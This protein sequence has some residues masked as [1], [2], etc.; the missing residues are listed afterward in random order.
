MRWYQCLKYTKEL[1]H[2]RNQRGETNLCILHI[3]HPRVV[4]DSWFVPV[5]I[6]GNTS[7][8]STALGETPCMVKHQ[9]LQFIHTHTYWYILNT[10]TAWNHRRHLIKLSFFWTITY[11]GDH[12]QWVTLQGYSA[13]IF[14]DCM[15]DFTIVE[16]CLKKIYG[17]TF[18]YISMFDTFIKCFCE[19]HW[20]FC[21]LV[22]THILIML[23][24]KPKFYWTIEN[25]KKLF[26]QVVI[27]DHANLIR[28]WKLCTIFTL[29]NCNPKYI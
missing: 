10:R 8:G 14:V 9:R 7:K 26:Y 29:Y 13:F 5:N 3:L 11:Y 19:I 2:H 1:Q 25:K 4:L 24:F 6:R 16:N 18:I 20:W 17:T 21:N 28:S 27:I 23:L 22:I 12:W 15:M